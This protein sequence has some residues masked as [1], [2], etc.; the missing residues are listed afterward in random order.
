MTKLKTPYK[1]LVPPLATSEFEVLKAD[2]KVNGVQVP[3]AIDEDNNILDGH[4]RYACDK[5]AP[6]IVIAGMT[7]LEKRAYV[8][9]AN[10]ARRNLSPAQR[11]E[12]RKVQR[13]L[14]RELK[15]ADKG[16]YTQSRLAVMLGVSRR[17]VD[18]WLDT[19]SNVKND[20]TCSPGRVTDH[21]TDSRVKVA[22]KQKAVIAD[23]V[24]AGESQSQVAADYGVTQQTISTIVKSA[25]NIHSRDDDKAR[26]TAH[27][28]EKLFDLRKGDFREV[29]ADVIGVSLILTDPPYPKESLPLWSDLGKWAST[30]L[31]DDGLLVAYSGQMFLP[32]VLARLSEYLEYWWCGAVIH[33]GSGNLTPLGHPVRK[34][35][36]KWKPLVMFYKR[37]GH[38]YAKTFSDLIDGTGPEKEH[39]NWAQPVAEAAEVIERFTK[40]NELVVDPFAGSGGFCKAACDLGRKAIGAEIL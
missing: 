4:H 35:I 5:N 18:E 38:G 21:A 1:N 34:V 37:G 36:N 22:P 14:C 17:T 30:A 39:H 20:T 7:D 24:A 25:N 27:L 23:R 29:L 33:K 19:T 6:T 12:L 28:K 13:K 40:K 8:I 16:T 32:D 9:K 31:A 15:A 2:I 11:K 26:K 10:V 3:V